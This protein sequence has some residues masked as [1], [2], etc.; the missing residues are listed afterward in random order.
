M[1]SKFSALVFK[2]QLDKIKRY[3]LNKIHV[4]YTFTRST[5]GVM[6][7]LL[8]EAHMVVEL[9]LKLCFSFLRFGD[10]TVIKGNLARLNFCWYK[11]VVFIQIY[12]SGSQPVHTHGNQLQHYCF[13]IGQASL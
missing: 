11:M 9:Y 12:Q 8:G 1:D 6:Q 3:D 2:H 7:L 10:N 5:F 4:V 13:P